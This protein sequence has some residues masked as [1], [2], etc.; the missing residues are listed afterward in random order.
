MARIGWRV[1]G[2]LCVA[3]GF[4]AAVALAE[5]PSDKGVGP[6]K[7]VKLG[8]IDPAMAKAGAALFEQKCS[9]CHKF[10]ERYVGPALKGVTQRRTPE[11]IM[12]MILDPQKMTTENAEAQ[13]LLGEYMVQMTFQNVKESEAREILEYFRQVDGGGAAPK[14]DAAAGTDK[15]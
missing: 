2:G 6:I 4:A 10:D 1:A 5:A 9:A 15:Q 12:N 11:Y 14:A 8:P 7:E 3:V 13:K